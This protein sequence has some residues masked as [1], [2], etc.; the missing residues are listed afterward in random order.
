M[1]QA[2]MEGGRVGQRR[3]V[4]CVRACYI[5]YVNLDTCRE[6]RSLLQREAVIDSTIRS[7]VRLLDVFG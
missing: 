4:N 2:A 1:Q 3:V 5:Q 7:R 6:H